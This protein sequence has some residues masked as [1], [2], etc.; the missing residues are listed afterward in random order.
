M[1]LY[2]MILSRIKNADSKKAWGLD[3]RGS[4]LPGEEKRVDGRVLGVTEGVGGV[5][6][7]G[8]RTALHTMK[9]SRQNT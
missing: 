3:E 1:I 8:L 2:E 4:K 9:W 6:F 7:L 5:N